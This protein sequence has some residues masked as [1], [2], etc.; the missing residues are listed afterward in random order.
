MLCSFDLEFFFFMYYVFPSLAVLYMFSELIWYVPRVSSGTEGLPPA[1]P[2]EAR[3][4]Q[5]SESVHLKV[6]VHAA[7]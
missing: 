5:R 3:A 2:P 7:K 4:A 6:F 1:G